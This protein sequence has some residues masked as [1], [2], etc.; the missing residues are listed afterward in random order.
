MTKDEIK[1]PKEQ[2]QNI[3]NGINTILK[4]LPAEQRDKAISIA[5]GILR[6]QPLPAEQASVAER[7]TEIFQARADLEGQEEKDKT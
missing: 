3:A 7:V 5:K 4:A 1:D 6:K 2:A